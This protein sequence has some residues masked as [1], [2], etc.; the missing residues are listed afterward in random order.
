M[1]NKNDYNNLIF[2]AKGLGFKVVEE[3]IVF[4]RKSVELNGKVKI[5]NKEKLNIKIDLND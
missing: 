2:K 4:P 3:D 5:V 1:G